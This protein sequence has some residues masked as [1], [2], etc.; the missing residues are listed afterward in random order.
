MSS[1][2]MPHV[3]ASENGCGCGARYSFLLILPLRCLQT[4]FVCASL[5]SQL[6]VISCVTDM[7]KAAVAYYT[8]SAGVVDAR[9]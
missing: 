6:P 9:S 5:K 8:V 3:S 4:T 2:D 7:D 1:R